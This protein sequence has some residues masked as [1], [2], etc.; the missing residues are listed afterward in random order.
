LTPDK[1]EQ[2]K[3][4]LLLFEESLGVYLGTDD[5]PSAAWEALGALHGVDPDVLEV[6]QKVLLYVKEVLG[7]AR[8]NLGRP[9]QFGLEM[10]AL[11]LLA[12]P[13]IVEAIKDAA[14]E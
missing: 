7:T 1:E 13:G 9:E 14:D 2:A 5:D 10:G 12:I 4:L 11:S 6:V 3:A 8:T